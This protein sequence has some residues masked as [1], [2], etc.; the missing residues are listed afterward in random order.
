MYGARFL[1]CLLGGL[2]T[3]ACRTDG[4]GP[5]TGPGSFSASW[6]GADTGKL[7]AA[8][9]AVFCVEGNHLEL[10]ASRGDLGVGLAVYPTAGPDAGTYE[11]FDPAADT[12]KRPGVTAAARWFT[13]REI[14]AYQSDRGTLTLTRKGEALSG[15]FAIHLRKVA[16]DTDTLVLSGRFSGVVP[17]PCVPDTVSP[18]DSGQ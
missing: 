8:P 14:K 15:T 12:V 6:I 7:S 13:E 16:A 2:L 17:G 5:T 18:P 10:I 9:R 11:G 4:S 1:P 3:A